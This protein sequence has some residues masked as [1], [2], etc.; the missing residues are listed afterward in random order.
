MNSEFIVPLL[1]L[2]LA[3]FALGVVAALVNLRD[4][5]PRRFRGP[6]YVGVVVLLT[7]TTALVSRSGLAGILAGVWVAFLAFVVSAHQLEHWRKET[8]ER[9]QEARRKIIVGAAALA[10]A[11]VDPG[12]RAALRVV[13]RAA[14]TRD[15]DK[16]AIP[17]LLAFVFPVDQLEQWRKEAEE[18]KR[19]ARRKICGGRRLR[20]RRSR[21]RLS[22]GAARGPPGRRHARYRQG[23]DPRSA[24][25]VI[26]PLL[27]QVAPTTQPARM[28]GLRPPN[29]PRMMLRGNV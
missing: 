22:G 28:H 4:F 10:Y 16:A 11:E 5:I 24:P 6:T 25:S 17:D 18:R 20:P 21:S 9:K 1:A 3:L 27:A 12:F 13:L 26:V 2:F 23:R 14:V 15:I 29:D 7:A 8:E 19:D